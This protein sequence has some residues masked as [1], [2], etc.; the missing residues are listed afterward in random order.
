ML[1]LLLSCGSESEVPKGGQ[2]EP[3]LDNATCDDD[4]L[5]RCFYF[6]GSQEEETSVCAPKCLP[7][8]MCP[9]GPES[10]DGGP[11]T[12]TCDY[13]GFCLLEC[14]ED[15]ECPKGMKCL[16]TKDV[17]DLERVCVWTP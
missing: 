11:T 3:C 8:K 13:K 4:N 1:L 12:L 7:D 6:Y 16:P 10:S 5:D 9:L 15:R 17:S 14:I 2:W